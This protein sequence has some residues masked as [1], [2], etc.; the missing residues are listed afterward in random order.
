MTVGDRIRD[1]RK[2]AKMTQQGLADKLGVSFTL[3][4]QYERSIRTPKIDTLQRIAF[5]LGIKLSDLLDFNSLFGEVDNQMLQKI[6]SDMQL[7]FKGISEDMVYQLSINIDDSDHEEDAIWELGHFLYCHLSPS[8]NTVIWR[9]FK[10]YIEVI[11]L[12]AIHYRSICSEKNHDRI[13]SMTQKI[14]EQLKN[15]TVD[16]L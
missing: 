2:A 4:S 12:I 9:I 8:H 10:Y 14:K 3:I 15:R 1:A 16:D 5:A 6:M 11:D 13:S 7:E